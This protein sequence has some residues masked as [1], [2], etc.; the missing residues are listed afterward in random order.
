MCEMIKWLNYFGMGSIIYLIL[1]FSK[2]HITST[3]SLKEVKHTTN[4]IE[5]AKSPRHKLTIDLRN[6]SKKF[7]SVSYEHLKGLLLVHSAT[8]I[9][10]ILL[11]SLVKDNAKGENAHTYTIQW[12][13]N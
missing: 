6:I 13:K 7:F 4:V 11:V 2:P 3:T 8:T 12:L 1:S 10:A 9:F 5:R